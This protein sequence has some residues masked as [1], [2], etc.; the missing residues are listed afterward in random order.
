M[1]GSSFL[2]SEKKLNKQLKLLV[3]TVIGSF[4]TLKLLNALYDYLYEP[5]IGTMI[6]NNGADKYYFVI[7]DYYVQASQLVEIVIRYFV[8]II[9]LLLL[10]NIVK[11]G[12][13]KHYYSYA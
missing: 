8:F 11:Y 12:T 6:H 5:V 10:Y 13:R 1:G 7:G 3:I 2:L 9:I 4:I